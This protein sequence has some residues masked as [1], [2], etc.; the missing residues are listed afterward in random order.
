MLLCSF[1]N[2][3]YKFLFPAK[4]DVEHQSRNDN[5]AVTVNL[6]S[7]LTVKSIAP[8]GE[9][10]LLKEWKIVEFFVGKDYFLGITNG[11]RIIQSISSRF[12]SDFLS[13]SF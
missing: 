1:T 9:Q 2:P 6:V 4:Y 11:T 5:E 10:H 3:C 7:S 8:N 12:E 13:G